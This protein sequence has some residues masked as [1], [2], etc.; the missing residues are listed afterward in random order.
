M[1][2]LSENWQYVLGVLWLATYFVV[3]FYF[4]R[5]P[6][7]RGARVV[8]FL[9]PWANPNRQRPPFPGRRTFFLWAFGVLIVLVAIFFVPGFYRR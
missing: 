9:E 8:F 5:H 1:D 3:V 4:R 7:A 2:W 6:D